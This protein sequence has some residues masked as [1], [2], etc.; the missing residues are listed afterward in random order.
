[1]D[2]E[3]HKRFL[4]YREAFAYFAQK[5]HPQLNAADFEAADT[6]QRTLEALGS[7]RSDEQEARFIELTVLLLRD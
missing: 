6:E 2:R 3:V 5:G 4:R 1:M 7:G